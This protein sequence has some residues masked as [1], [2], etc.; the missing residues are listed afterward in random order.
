MSTNAKVKGTAPE[1]PTPVMLSAEERLRHY[2]ADE[3]EE[4]NL[5]P[6]KARWLREQAYLRKI[7][8][9]KVGGKLRFRLDHILAISLAGEIGPAQ[10]RGRRAA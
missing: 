8:A 7:P 1:A 2:S 3:I 6:V 4:L 10:A 9:T 5:L